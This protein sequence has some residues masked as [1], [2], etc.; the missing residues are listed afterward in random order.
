MNRARLAVTALCN[1]MGIR[2]ATARPSEKQVRRSVFSILQDNRLCSM[3]SVTGENRAHINTAYF[4]YSNELEL[5][6]LSHP[7]SLHCRNLSKNSSMAITIFCSAQKWTGLDQ[8]LQLFGTC[9]QARGLQAGKAE[10]LYGK[11]FPAYARWRASLR[12]DD[13]A[14]RYRFYL[15]RTSKVKILDEKSFGDAVFVYAIVKRGYRS[16]SPRETRSD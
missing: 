11:R 6:F 9:S 1:V 7:G 10:R 13:V 14:R 4:C 5:Y 15:F 8:G 16:G 3:A 2:T 12:R